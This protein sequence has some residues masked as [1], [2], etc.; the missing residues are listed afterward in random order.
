MIARSLWRHLLYERLATLELTGQVVDL[1]GSRKSAYTND[2]KGNFTITVANFE[3][4]APGDIALNLEQPFTISS[5]QYDGVLCINVLEHIFNYQNVINE[6]R[7]ILKPG[8]RAIFAVPFL[9]QVHPSPHDHWRFTAETLER[10]FTEAGFTEINIES[11]G[12]GVFGAQVQM[13][14]N[15]LHFSLLRRLANTFAKFMDKLVS[16]VFKKDTFSKQFYSLGYV[17]TARK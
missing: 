7:R 1:G 6:T 9:I 11:I 12:T 16:K 3:G 15:V 8:G 17:V 10:L 2:F 4:E 14:Y 5:E 13:M